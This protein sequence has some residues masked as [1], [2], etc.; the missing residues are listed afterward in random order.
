MKYRSKPV[1]IDA[2]QYKHSD[3]L[4]FPDWIGQAFLERKLEYNDFSAIREILV[5]T[6]EG[7]MSCVEGSWIIRGTEGEL[8]PCKDSVFKTKY[9]PAGE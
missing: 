6:L 9:E 8:Y 5:K 4:V 3:R 2:W 7:T 1:V